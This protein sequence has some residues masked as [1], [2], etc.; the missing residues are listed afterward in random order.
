LFKK[1]P[2]SS[3]KP[4]GTFYMDWEQIFKQ[5]CYSVGQCLTI[6]INLSFGRTSWLLTSKRDMFL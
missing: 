3:L 5:F 1:H 6:V 4:I 2:K